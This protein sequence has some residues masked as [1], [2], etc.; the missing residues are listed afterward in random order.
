MQRYLIRVALV[1]TTTKYKDPIT[2]ILSCRIGVSDG[3][4]DQSRFEDF[5]YLLLR[6][7][8]LIQNTFDILADGPK[9]EVLSICE[10]RGV[11]ADA[12]S[13]GWK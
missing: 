1:F 2:R 4:L 7:E 3:Y 6:P 5:V 8:L 9:Q 10:P 11:D 12:T 13:Q